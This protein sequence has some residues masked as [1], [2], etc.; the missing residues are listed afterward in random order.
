M[1]LNMRS[2]AFQVPKFKPFIIKVNYYTCLPVITLKK[3]TSLCIKIELA[4]SVKEVRNIPILVLI[5]EIFFYIFQ[6][7]I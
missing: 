1:P 6:G 7:N 3:L 2:V 4:A 5:K